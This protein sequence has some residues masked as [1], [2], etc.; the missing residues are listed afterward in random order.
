MLVA[1]LVLLEQ[2]TQHASRPRCKAP[3]SGCTR[4]AAATRRCP[5]RTKPKRTVG[6]R[7]ITWTLWSR[8]GRFMSRPS[9]PPSQVPRPVSNHSACMHGDKMLVFGDNGESSAV[10]SLDLAVSKLIWKHVE[11][12]GEIPQARLSHTAT[13]VATRPRLS[14][15]RAR[16][17]PC[18]CAQHDAL[19]LCTMHSAGRTL[20]T[21]ELAATQYPHCTRC[22]G[23]HTPYNVHATH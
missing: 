19:L 5:K 6:G 23:C 22:T 10:F 1:S 17:R 2:Y 7:R 9:S 14:L 3:V 4:G 15:R 20:C 21:A 18:R 11:A 13:M 16:T 12:K 8:A